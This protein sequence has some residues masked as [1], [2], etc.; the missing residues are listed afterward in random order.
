MIHNSDQSVFFVEGDGAGSGSD[1]AETLQRTLG[2]LASSTKDIQVC[3]LICDV[4]VLVS[5]SWSRG[6]RFSC[7]PFCYHITTVG[8]SSVYVSLSPSSTELN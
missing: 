6:C 7:W 3:W 8:V 1:F 2:D 5:D 4:V